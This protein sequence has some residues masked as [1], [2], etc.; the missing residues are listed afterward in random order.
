MAK[1]SSHITP[2]PTGLVPAKSSTELINEYVERLRDSGVLQ[3]TIAL[4]LRFGPNYVSMLKAGDELLPL[5]R[6]VA[7]AHAVR[8]TPAERYHL[9]HTRLMELHGEKGELCVETIAQWA[10]EAYSP[11]GDE[12]KLIELWRSATL[13]APHLLSGLLDDPVRAARVHAAMEAVVQAELQAM[14]DEA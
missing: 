1:T 9:V 12:A 7:F 13:P 14:A 10:D 2:L 5:P 6:V 8:L 4:S 11:V 3:K